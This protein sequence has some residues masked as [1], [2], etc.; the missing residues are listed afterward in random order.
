MASLPASKAAEATTSF[1]VLSFSAAERAAAVPGSERVDEAVA[2]FAKHGALLLRD[3]FEPSR[4]EALDRR[5]RSRYRV[6]LHKP[7]QADRR[8]LFTVDVEGP[9]ADPSYYAN[10]LVFPILQRLLGRD[11]ILGACSSVVSWPGAPPQ[12]VHR[13]SES[14]YGNFAIDVQ[15]PPYAVTLLMPLVRADAVTGSTR[16]WLGTHR[17]ADFA[18]ARA[19]PSVAHE[20]EPG[21]MLMTDSR[22]LHAGEPNRSETIR[23][24][25]YISYHRSWFRDL[26]GY[27]KRPPV[28]LGSGLGRAIDPARRG[29][30]RIADER[31]PTDR[32][33]WVLRRAVNRWLPP[34]LRRFVRR[35]RGGSAW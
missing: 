27:E 13:D 25:L 23:P 20:V 18:T 7:D 24:L 31:D 12:T 5:Y 33:R 10:P 3:V 15:L 32:A 17:V 4:I 19:M 29:M 26:G 21:S 9:F 22:V 8:R 16:V 2:L 30:F 14:L 34:S 11:C 1:P 35:H 28:S 6:E